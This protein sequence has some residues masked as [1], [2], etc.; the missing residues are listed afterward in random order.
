MIG[1]GIILSVTLSL[2]FWASWSIYSKYSKYV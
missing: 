1:Y 2:Y